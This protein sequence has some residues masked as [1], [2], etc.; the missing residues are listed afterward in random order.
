MPDLAHDLPEGWLCPDLGVRVRSVITSS[1]GPND[2]ADF[3]L[4]FHAGKTAN[5][6]RHR[7]GLKH[8]L[9]AHRVQWLKQAHGAR[10]VAIE[11]AELPGEKAVADAMWTREQGIG[12][13][14]LT[15]DCLPVLLASGDGSCVAVAHAGWQGLA[16][17]VLAET[18]ATLPVA[19]RDL[20][21]FVGPAI[22]GAVYEVGEDV[23]SQFPSRFAG[24]HSD[25]AKRY[26]DLI[27][28]AR[29]QL[30]SL[31]VMRIEG[32]D[33]CTFRDGAYYS[34]RRWLQAGGVCGRFASVIMRL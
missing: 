5:T 14:I 34:H 28:I 31:G 21:A 19:A 23:W 2:V 33:L 13:A 16:R 27:G 3:N 11:R 12:L 29:A 32:G 6:A 15:A 8:S 1:V 17:G 7:A 26:L 25:P 10:C 24:P 18:I 22:S 20:V 30:G 4:A 9:G